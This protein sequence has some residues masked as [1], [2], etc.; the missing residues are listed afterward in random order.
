MREIRLSRHECGLSG[1]S[2]VWEL[3]LDGAAGQHDEG[4]C[5]GG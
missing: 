4:E 1:G 5:C 3:E 2:F